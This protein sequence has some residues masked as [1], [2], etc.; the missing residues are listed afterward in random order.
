LP[1]EYKL[2][3]GD[4][5]RVFKDAVRDLIPPPILQRPKWGFAPPTSEWLRTVFRPLVDEYLSVERLSA[6]G[7]FRAEAVR[8]LVEAHWSKRSYALWTIWPILIFQL[9]HAIYI[10]NELSAAP[11]SAGSL[12]M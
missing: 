9:W 2:R 6:G 5:K 8:A 3:N 10:T 1:L 7:F 12:F 4:F 11:L